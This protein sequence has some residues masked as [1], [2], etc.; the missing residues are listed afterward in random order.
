MMAWLFSEARVL[1]SIEVAEGF[2][3]EPRVYWPQRDRGRL[4]IPHC[5]CIHTIGMRFAID[6][7]YVDANNMVDQ[8]STC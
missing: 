5:R 6:V 1:A 7:A 4:A 3:Q 8:D 2:A